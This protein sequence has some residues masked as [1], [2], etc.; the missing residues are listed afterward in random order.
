VRL[1]L[2][3]LIVVLVP[4]LVAGCGGGDDA[5]SGTDVN[6]LLD[7]T[8]SGGKD[9]NSGR[10]DL[11]L[12][13]ESQG[14]EQSGPLT[15]DISGPFQSEGE[16]RLPKFQIAASLQGAGENLEAGV[17]STGDA[18]YVSLQGTDYQVSRMVFQQ[19]KAGFEQTQEQNRQEGQSFA[20]LGIDP[21]RWLTNARNAGESEVGGTET[22][23][24][25]GGVDVGR[26]LDDVNAA[27]ERARSL[28]LQGAE[29]LPERLTDEQKRQAAEA[30]R[31]LAVEIHTGKEDK[32]LRRMRITLDLQAPEGTDL[33]VGSARVALDLSLLELNEDQEISAPESP[34]PFEE[35]VGSL[36]GLGL[37][38]G[39]ADGG[40]GGG[41][42][43]SQENLEKYSQCI[44]DAGNDTQKAR[45]CAQ[46]LT[47]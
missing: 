17:T 16:G 9:I 5:D 40:G 23:K 35:L 2:P 34:R 21:R 31:N 28:G 38:G 6:R 8:F 30:V 44:Q 12:R 20:S 26:L 41:G 45:E 24:I 43:A 33:G 37:G 29:E 46:L 39:G 15:V 22:I 42:G 3:L 10:L 1:L 47:P 11:G 32:I 7:Q 14:G 25:T 36:G 27:L 13:V 4:G 19:F 18:G